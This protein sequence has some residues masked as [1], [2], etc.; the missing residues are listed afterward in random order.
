MKYYPIWSYLSISGM[1]APLISIAWYLYFA[2]NLLNTS[3]NTQHCLILGVSVWLGYMADR[4]FDIRF[5]KEAQLISLRHQFCKENEFKL[6]I[7]WLI[8]LIPITI[9]SLNTLN[10]DKIFAGLILIL[11]ILLYNYLNQCFSRKR[12][13]KEICAAA[14]FSYGTLFLIE[15]PLKIEEFIH[16]T[17][18]CFLN[19]LILTHKEKQVDK[20]MGINSWTHP[21][22][23]RSIFIIIAL[24]CIYFLITF[25]GIF[26]PFF[27]T[28]LLCLVLHIKSHHI[29]KEKFRI[30]LE[31]L[32][33]IIPLWAL[34]S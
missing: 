9:F 13:P 1:D 4:L 10:S 30:T 6:W 28:C 23:Y 33:A 11:F 12:F 34:I 25:Q 29:D 16:L 31:S 17:L 8:I 21:F 14:L 20:L 32:Y 24:F 5:K 2:Q 26:N 3:L 15:S 7:L 27:A 19:C 22:T 18:I